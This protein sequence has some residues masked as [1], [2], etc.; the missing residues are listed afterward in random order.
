MFP[1]RKKSFREKIKSHLGLDP[2]NLPVIT[3]QFPAY[4]HANVQLGMDEYVSTNGRN[5]TS[6]GIQGGSLLS[7]RD[8]NLSSLVAKDSWTSMFGIGTYKEG[9][10]THSTFH[11]EGEETMKCVQKALYLVK[12]DT[13]PI[14]VLVRESDN[15][16][17]ASSGIFVE[18]MAAE[19]NIADGF[20]KE[21][22]AIIKE[23]NV[24][25]GKILSLSQ[26][27]DPS[28]GSSG[29]TGLKFHTVS[30]VTREQIILPDK[31][32][33]RIERQTIEAVKYSEALKRAKRKLKRGI[34][35]HGVPGTGKTLTALYL[36]TQMEG[37]TV[38]MLTGRSQGLIET[39]TEI[40]RWLQPSMIIIEDID[41]IA[42]ERSQN[43][44]CNTSIMFE[45]LNQMD[46]LSD[47]SDVLF[48]LTT[49]RPEVLEPALASR[50]GRVDQ[51][52]EVMLPDDECRQKLIELYSDGLTLE[53]EQMDRL[54]QR[55]K[56]ASGA[57]IYELMRKAALFAAPEGEPIV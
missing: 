36:A 33:E 24:Y 54:I 45:L 31:L 25:R 39:S 43:G 20:I 17:G 47:D 46:G 15:M 23:K 9:P 18:C 50:P 26:T 30:P 52:Y 27:E 40:A 49:N 44:N 34:L 38:L 56:G 41:L 28:G 16:F 35:L 42:E 22:K 14:A 6:M 21:L 12:N 11:L 8:V 37:R 1:G 57:F 32:L 51:A 5:A 13:Q 7:F 4:N 55:T 10:I 48:L 53:V 19:N 29:Q 3:E 2:S